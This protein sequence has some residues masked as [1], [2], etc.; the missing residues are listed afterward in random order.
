MICQHELVKQ[1]KA[2]N[3]DADEELIHRAYAFSMKAHSSQTRESGDP[4]FS[5]PLEVASILTE[6]KL[7]TDS[8]VTALLHDTVE[9]TSSTLE[10]IRSLFGDTIASLVD[11]VTKLTQIELQSVHTKQAENFR[12]LVLA[13]SNDIRVLLVKLADRLHNMRTLY[14]CK[15]AEKR[16]RISMETMEIYAPLAERI[17]LNHI[18]DELEDLSFAE[19]K[20]DARESIL[21]RLSFLRQ[22][23]ENY[24]EGILS[25]LN[26]LFK[27]H[28]LSTTIS[29]R[30]KSPYSI[31]QKM[32]LKNI[33][34]E[35]LSDIMAF[36]IVV[37]T[38]PEC[39]QALGIIHS[40]YAML[41]ERFKDYISTPKPN[42][43]QSIHTTVLGPHQQCIEIQIRTHHM[44]EINERGVAAHWS[45]KQGVPTVTKGTAGSQYRWLRGLLD[46]LDHAS[47]PEEFMEN[48][49]LEMFHDQVF[50]FTP[51]GDLVSLP[52]GAT[53]I[54]FAYAVHSEIGDHCVGVR[55]NGRMVPLRTL[56]K[57]GD[58]IEVT[59]SKA[60]TPSPT[61]ERIAITGKAKACIRRFIRSQK[62]EQF[63]ELGRSL[64]QKTFRQEGFTFGEKVLTP[65]LK[66]LD[67]ASADDLFAFV[68]EGLKSTTEVLKTVHPEHTL[69]Q[70][71]E[72]QQLSFPP[73]EQKTPEEGSLSLK[74]LIPGMAVHYAGCCHPLPGDKI[75]GIVVTGKGIT[76]HTYDC[77][78]LEQFSNQPE[79]WIDVEWNKDK[80]EKSLYIGRLH[81]IILN[82]VGGLANLT[83]LIGKNAGNILN[84][85]ITNR[86][87]SFF[88]MLIDIEV[89]DAAHLSNII[90]IMRTSTLINFVE[91]SRS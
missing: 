44:H 50:C 24:I 82:K 55:I 65:Y 39:Y 7:D 23:G 79:R 40:T 22:E 5:H 71:E 66:K 27:K 87:E 73:K 89:K 68:G 1:V 91:R 47:T 25:E 41:P 59:T 64:L 43:Y 15:S 29:G 45:Y 53:A 88:E 86:S 12:K 49:K 75:V 34:F 35:Q 10:E 77:H 13:M 17:G 14:Y 62:R 42:H 33:G 38:M 84:L 76:V 80:S 19:I 2:Y 69:V 83:T 30:E 70:P 63:I 48:T 16:T 37:E 36:R 11:G 21:T 46:I 3:P 81:V 8:I 51:K 31:W 67:A 72:N 61:W 74:G 57:N 52:S 90:G 32:R 26:A 85:K 60:Q 78:N 4:Y 58:Q 6:L 54:D 28:K 20:P 9:D 56:L 18:K